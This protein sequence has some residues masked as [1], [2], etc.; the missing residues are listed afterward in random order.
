MIRV[1]RILNRFNLGGPTYNASYLSRHLPP[2][3]ETL[4][5]GGQN[6]PSEKNSKF[7]P[8]KM[9][10]E[11]VLLDTMRREVNPV[12]DLRAY[13]QLLKI[14]KEYRP[15]IVHTHASKAGALGRLA[16]FQSRIPVIV[17]TYHGHVFDGYFG[18]TAAMVYRNLERGLA[19]I[20]TGIIA[21]SHAQMHDLVFRHH[22]CPE[23]K[24][25]IIPLGFD[26]DRF[27]Q[28][29]EEKR[30]RFREEY[31]LNDNEIAI[32]IVGRLVPIKNH[33]LFLKAIKIV[34]EKSQNPIRAFIVGD[35]ESRQQT[36]QTARDLN[37]AFT[38]WNKHQKVCTITFT[39][40]VTEM[41]WLM[42]GM[43][44]IALSSI[45]EGTPVSLIEAQAAGK[46][47][48]TTNVGGISDVVL[49]GKTALLAGNSP[50]EFAENLLRLTTEPGL[51]EE[52][53][54]HGWGVVEKKFSYHRLVNETAS[55]YFDLLEKKRIN[56]KN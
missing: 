46:P 45:N 3:F 35:G 6:D 44:I 55:Y 23:E 20:S 34:Q 9:G 32:G 30:K 17:H 33:S 47:I 39:G 14:M 11:P 40:W 48:V 10:V 42:A 7:I 41:D 24:I 15:H 12:S 13:F 28:N 16:A 18:K 38:D 1:L 31:Q 50:H 21:I 52:M 36:E 4:L 56:V 2:E 49:P 53:G 19:K 27:V 43:D 25:R 29:R 5:V 37:L 26:L 8:H 54:K 22:I 51:R